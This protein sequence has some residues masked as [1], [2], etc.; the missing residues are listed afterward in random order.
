M[1]YVYYKNTCLLLKVYVLSILFIFLELFTKRLIIKCCP[2]G[3]NVSKC[4][5]KKFI[6]NACSSFLSN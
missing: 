4:C 3:I 5:A 2:D 1:I 6:G